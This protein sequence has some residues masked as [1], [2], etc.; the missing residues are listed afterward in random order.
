MARGWRARNGNLLEG[1]AILADELV[2]N[3]NLV[4]AFEAMVDLL[5]PHL[6]GD[7]QGL[8]TFDGRRDALRP[9]P[10]SEAM[11]ADDG[12]VGGMA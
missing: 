2:G 1:L 8:H 10:W 6:L 3:P 12:L 11:Q 5:V 7:L 4:Y 9:G